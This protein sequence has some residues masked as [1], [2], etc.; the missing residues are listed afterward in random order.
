MSAS[1]QSCEFES[2][3]DE[4]CKKLDSIQSDTTVVAD[5]QNVIDMTNRK[6]AID[7]SPQELAK[8]YYAAFPALKHETSPGKLLAPKWVKKANQKTATKLMNDKGEKCQKKTND[9]I[10]A[11][12]DFDDAINMYDLPFDIKELLDDSQKA[13]E[14]RTTEIYNMANMTNYAAP[15]KFIPYGTNTSIWSNDTVDIY[16]IDSFV[17]KAA[18]REETMPLFDDTLQ[19]S[20]SVLMHDSDKSPFVT[21]HPNKRR[22]VSNFNATVGSNDLALKKNV[23]NNDDLLT[24]VNSHFRPIN[25]KKDGHVPTTTTQ[26]ADGTTF[27]VS[28]NWNRVDYVRSRNGS[29]FMS[30]DPNRRHRYGEVKKDD[31]SELVVKF[32]ICQNDKACQTD[33]DFSIVTG[34]DLIHDD[35]EALNDFMTEYLDS[36]CVKQNN[37]LEMLWKK[38]PRCNCQNTVIWSNAVLDHFAQDEW[39]D[40]DLFNIWKSDDVSICFSLLNDEKSKF[41]NGV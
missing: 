34:R 38:D 13:P 4:L 3:I 35:N 5:Q 17:A 33:N 16:N 39:D 18:S 31:G 2:L 1:D 12:W 26:H 8:R 24:S 36:G 28:N 23:D 9:K 14:K 25:E 20:L 27:S 29:I 11:N 22:V 6:P 30:T 10:M 19:I 15:P 37:G 41:R 7:V 40:R 32:L 21:V